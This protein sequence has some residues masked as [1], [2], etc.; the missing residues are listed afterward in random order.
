MRHCS[1]MQCHLVI[2]V[3]AQ[4]YNSYNVGNKVEKTIEE[5]MYNNNNN[6]DQ[7]TQY[8]TQTMTLTH[9]HTHT[10]SQCTGGICN[11]F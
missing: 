3:D 9:T 5:H 10:Q 7:E 2:S 1:K 11:Q 4:T 8:V 6:N